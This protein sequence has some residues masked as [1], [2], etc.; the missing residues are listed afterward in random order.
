MKVLTRVTV[1]AFPGGVVP[2]WFVDP[3]DGRAGRRS[4]L[5]FSLS[6]SLRFSVFRFG[7]FSFGGLG[8]GFSFCLRTGPF[9]L[10]R[11]LCCVEIFTLVTLRAFS[12]DEVTARISACTGGRNSRYCRGD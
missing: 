8:L 5:G 10:L 7:G 11:F 12:C 6:L 3:Y 4:R 1:G 9:P 2:A